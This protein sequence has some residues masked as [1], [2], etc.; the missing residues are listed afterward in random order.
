VNGTR[1]MVDELLGDN[2]L[3]TLLSNDQLRLEMEN[4]AVFKGFK[5]PEITF[6][7]TYKFDLPK[8]VKRAFSISQRKRS[9]SG[10][11][12]VNQDSDSDYIA[13]SPIQEEELSR[14]KAPEPLPSPTKTNLIPKRSNSVYDSSKKQRI[15]SWTDRILFKEES[16]SSQIC[17]T[18]YDACMDM[19]HSDHKP[20]YAIFSMAFDWR[21]V[22]DNEDSKKALT[23]Q[24]NRCVI[25]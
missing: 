10:A 16:S 23:S 12:V 1:K 21:K 3:E 19:M 14:D 17:A 8:K 2:M 9:S 18:K 25:L 15:P 11:S 20:V 24:K 22:F 5:E 13:V 6:L 7:P 4:G